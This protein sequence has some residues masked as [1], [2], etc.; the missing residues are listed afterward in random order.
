MKSWS[1]GILSLGRLK[2]FGENMQ[3]EKM[4]P[5][6]AAVPSY[7]SSSACGGPDQA[8]CKSQDL[9]TRTDEDTLT[10][11]NAKVSPSDRGPQ[12]INGFDLQRL[13]GVADLDHGSDVVQCEAAIGLK[14]ALRPGDLI[15]LGIENVTVRYDVGK[16]GPEN[17]D[18][19][20]GLLMVKAIGSDAKTIRL[21]SVYTGPTLR[22]QHIFK[23]L[24]SADEII[25]RVRAAAALREKERL[26]ALERKEAKENAKPKPKKPKPS[27]PPAPP[28]HNCSGPLLPGF[29][30]ALERSVLVRTTED[31]T[32][33]I[34][35]GERIQFDGYEEIYVVTQPRDNRTITLGTPY[36]K[37]D[38]QHLRACKYVDDSG[39]SCIPLSGCFDVIYNSHVLR[40]SEDV[41]EEIEP[42]EIIRV[43]AK[44][45]DVEAT[46]TSPRDERTLT[47]SG[48]YPAES[49][50]CVKACKLMN[51]WN[52]GRIPLC[53]TVSVRQDN[54]TVETTCDL[55]D[56]LN[57]GD[58]VK[59]GTHV[60]G[61][62][63][64]FTDSI[65]TL[66][67][68]YPEADASGLKATKQV[69]EIPLDGTISVVK[70]SDVI[71]TTA[72]LR[73]Q[74][75]PSDMIKIYQRPNDPDIFALISPIDRY[76]LTIPT[77]HPGPSAAGLKAYKIAGTMNPLLGTCRV[78]HGS[79]RVTTTSDLT[80]ALIPGDTVQ[81]K[82]FDGVVVKVDPTGFDFDAAYTGV[83]SDNANAFKKGKS[84][85][86]S[87]LEQLAMQKLACTSVYCTMK[88]EEAERALTFSFPR[89]LRAGL[90]ESTGGA[91]L[92][93][94]A[95]G[96][97]A[98]D[99]A[100]Q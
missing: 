10:L 49:A 9:K 21:E 17:S 72:D 3:L 42:G 92:A 74:V 37:E 63:S 15:R 91:S 82:E 13:P 19:A 59:I 97:G 1:N 24:V 54:V 94:G 67:K 89:A 62:V 86:Q 50:N 77:A 11:T 2:M 25:R 22:K 31:V 75:R 56:S 88:I 41:T 26:A 57:L 90:N 5:L 34:A 76:T 66:A 93:N 55:R 27:K 28:K 99:G 80:G 4:D 64:P 71:T 33:D 83:T 51:T 98:L 58:L 84:A 30:D 7:A 79:A 73:S 18:Y 85:E 23:K 48:P 43:H 81:I 16:I 44:T 14:D 96:A 61:I 69:R 12:W 95:S 87:T 6:A 8:P 70:G 40:S 47:I 68:A 100:E 78:V 20:R 36:E 60:S 32:A 52:G 65:L 46:V 29:F 53:G 38:H 35:D 39:D 45:G